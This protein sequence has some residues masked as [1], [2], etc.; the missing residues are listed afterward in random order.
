MLGVLHSGAT[1]GDPDV[2]LGHGAGGAARR[3][4]EASADDAARAVEDGPARVELVE[5]GRFPNGPAV[6]DGGLRWD[7]EALWDGIVAGLRE[8]G[9]VAARR[10][11]EVRG[12]GVDSWAVDH[13][14]LDDDGAL[15]ARP[16]CYRDSRTDAARERV[17]ARIPFAE[18]YAVNGLQD[19]PFTSVFQ[20]VA[21]AAGAGKTE[22]SRA[23]QVLLVPDLITYRLT[24]RRVAEVTNASTTGLLD[25]RTR[26]WSDAH[27]ARLAEEFPELGDLRARLPELVEPGTAV[28]HLLPGIREATGLGEVPVFAVASHDTASAVAAAPLDHAVPDEPRDS[29]RSGAQNGTNDMVPG[30]AAYISSGTWSLV[31]L[32]LDRPVLGDAS[33]EANF[34]NELG[35]DG[36]VR[37]LRNVMG[38]WILNEC[39]REW[40]EADGE[41]VDLPALL[42]D[43]AREPGGRCLIEVD[44]EEFLAP[45][46]M[47][48]R[49]RAAIGR[50]MSA[51]GPV[52]GAVRD[53]GGRAGAARG[54]RGPETAAQ[55]GA[56]APSGDRG[57]SSAAGSGVEAVPETRS[58]TV[59]VVLDSLA[60]AYAQVVRQA[61]ELAGVRVGAIHVVGG[62]SQN[63][64]LN[65]LTAEAAGLPVLA[66][67]VEGT[68]L[69][70]VL[71]QARAAGALTAHDGGPATPRDLRATVRASTHLRTYEA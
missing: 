17:Y 24:G 6:H 49:V 31:G 48:D 10:G 5:C 70:N 52:T 41:P 50:R 60:A 11:L 43:A 42:E 66:G 57:R 39:V 13:G 55:P 44:G 51:A 26:T 71:V 20:F 36:T 58:A 62:G 2:V 14:F 59:R 67:P 56:G 40:S 25:A 4:D 35:I 12:I 63:D 34:T 53:G 27:I 64:L 22:W 45:G 8:A 65:R 30:A 33:R 3:G 1:D 69:G 9:S 29:V 47:A 16:W 37:Y 15:L 28:G 23:A 54:D 38:L 32:E 18:H 7:V 21:S 46:G 68:A 19:L 61:G